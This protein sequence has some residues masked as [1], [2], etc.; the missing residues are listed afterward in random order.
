MQI[1]PFQRKR[2]YYFLLLIKISSGTDSWVIFDNKREGYN[3]DNDFLQ[4]NS[5]NVEA[6]EAGAKIDLLSNG[7]KLRGSGGGIG[8]TNDSGETYIYMAFAS[9]PFTTSTGIPCTAR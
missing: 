4:P 1:I 9:E 5:T 2:N 8:Q 3:Q 6:T 7:F